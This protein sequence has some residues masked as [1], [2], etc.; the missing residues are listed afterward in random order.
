MYVHTNII[1]LK[2]V[3]FTSKTFQLNENFEVD[4]RTLKCDFIGYSPAEK[5]T[6]NT[7]NGQIYLYINIP[8]EDSVISL[9]NSH[10]DLNFEVIK[11]AHNSRY[12]NGDDIRVINLDP[13]ALFSNFKLPISSESFWKISVIVTLFL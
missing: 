12:E 9:I 10:L 11:K 1:V 7:P 4:R 6:I 8:T 13:I 3:F 5:S 2:H